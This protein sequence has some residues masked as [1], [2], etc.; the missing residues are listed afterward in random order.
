[1]FRPAEVRPLPGYRLWV[2]FTDGVEGVVD[3]SHLA[4]R[5]VFSLWNE[6]GAFERVTI[7]ASGEIAWSCDIDICSDSVYMQI[8]NKSP[9]E[10]FPDLVTAPIH[11]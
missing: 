5:G 9:Q 1:M 10:L 8:T 11:A 2:R 7:G 3:L 4:G 6:E